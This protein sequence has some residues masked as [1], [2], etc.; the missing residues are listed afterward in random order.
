MKFERAVIISNGKVKIP[1]FFIKLIKK[2]DYIIAANGGSKHAKN[3]GLIPDLI[4]GDLDSIS[5]KD[6]VYFQKKGSDFR[7]FDP[8]KDKTD[9]QI[10]IEYVIEFGFKE[11]LLLCVFGDRID[12]IIANIFLLIKVVEAGIRVKIVDEYNEIFLI[13]NFGTIKGKIGDTVSLIPLTETVS[14]IELTGLKFHPKDGRLMMIDT[15][16]ISNILIKKV[17]TIR[18]DNGKLLV[19]KPNN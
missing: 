17:A 9:V 4:I 15:L 14:G 2:S 6:Y 1:E 19:I 13:Q 18:I 7:K 10:A 16:G 11:I 3:F 5:K 8:I 12:H